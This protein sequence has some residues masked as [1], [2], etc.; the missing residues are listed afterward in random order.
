MY[1]LLMVGAEGHWEERDGCDFDASRYLEHTV[2][3]LQERLRP[4]TP[5]VAEEL[6]QWPALFAY[7]LGWHDIPSSALARVGRLT[8]IENR[9]A[10]IRISYQFDDN[11]PPISASQLRKIKWDLDITRSELSRHHWAVKNIDLIEVL[12]KKGVL[13]G[14]P[15]PVAAP[16]LRASSQAVELALDDAERM[17]REGLPSNA[18]DRIHTVLHGY[19]VQV[20]DDADLILQ[21][22]ERRSMTGV[23][24]RLRQQHPHFTYT[25]PRVDLIERALNASATFLDAFN[26]LRNNASVAHPNELVVPEAE[27]MY[28]IN[29]ARSLLHYVEMKR[30]Q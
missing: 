28:L 14:L 1:S 25:G 23:F 5:A 12:R 20:C 22:A 24:S 6:M 10:Y 27:A 2:E 13:N 15:V 21:S 16:D 4:L 17:L 3:A 19:L 8:S 30:Q 26:T 9:G 29:M 11:L 7:E 18:V